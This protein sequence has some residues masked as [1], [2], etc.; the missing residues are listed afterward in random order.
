V[1]LSQ[2]Y[3]TFAIDTDTPLKKVLLINSYHKGYAWS[4]GIEKGVR[5]ILG[6]KKNIQLKT[7]EMDTKRNK[8]ESFRKNAGFKVK[9]FIEKFKPDVVIAADDNASK[10]V[11]KR[12]YQNAQLPF[13]FCG[14]NWDASIYDY[15]YTNAT[16]MIEISLV[17]KVIKHLKQY[18]KGQKIGFISGDAVTSRKELQYHKKLF[19]I[20]Y[21]KA[22]FVTH[23]TD[24]KAK[25]LQ[26]QSEVDMVFFNNHAGIKNWDKK[27]ARTFIANNIKKPSGSQYDFMAYFASIT[28]AKSP[29]EQ[30]IWSAQ[31]AL[32]ILNG[33]K[34]S[35]I[36]IVKNKTGKLIFNMKLIKKLNINIPFEILK[37]ATLI[38]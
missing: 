2:Q 16:G 24:W 7:I 4:D 15:P 21:D 6:N 31:S 12:Y 9:L 30:G 8:T 19:N 10:Y 14:V 27:Q 23:F 26:L 37:I 1:F 3:N 29:E 38:R 11:V 5:S 20:D 17:E 18:A 36:R 32:K 35:H 25:Y 22:Y 28:I 33:T 13:V 34:P